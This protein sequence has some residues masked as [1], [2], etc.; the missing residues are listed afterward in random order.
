MAVLSALATGRFSIIKP[1]AQGRYSNF[2]PCGRKTPQPP[3]SLYM[4]TVS[5]YVLKG[6]REAPQED[7]CRTFAGR[8]YLLVRLIVDAL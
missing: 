8:R 4:T 1:G 2:K 5:P 7:E 6:D 3:K